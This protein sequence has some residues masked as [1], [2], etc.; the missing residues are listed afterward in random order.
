MKNHEQ[1]QF[2][3]DD[4]EKN[5]PLLLFRPCSCEC[6]SRLGIGYLSGS[7][8]YGRGFTV[9]ITDEQVFLRLKAVLQNTG[10]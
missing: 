10:E 2:T 1:Q 7:D 5:R 4:G 8:A 6:D 3:W 9:W